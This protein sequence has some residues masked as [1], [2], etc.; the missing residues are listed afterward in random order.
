MK[1]KVLDLENPGIYGAEFITIGKVYDAI[2]ELDSQGSIGIVD[3][4]G[5]VSALFHGEFEVVNED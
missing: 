4:S 1:V 5:L 2:D 3:D